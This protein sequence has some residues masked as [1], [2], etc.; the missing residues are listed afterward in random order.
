MI[1]FK[2]CE[3]CRRHDHFSL[4]SGCLHNRAMIDRLLEDR[5]RLQAELKRLKSILDDMCDELCNEG[6]SLFG[7]HLVGASTSPESWFEILRRVHPI[8]PQGRR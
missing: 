3:A 5:D 4:C 6:E 7:V 8:W 1:D 2:L